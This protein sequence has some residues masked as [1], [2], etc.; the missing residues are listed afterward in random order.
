MKHIPFLSFFTLSLCL[1]YTY[2]HSLYL[3]LPFLYLY[4]IYFKQLRLYCT[5]TSLLFGLKSIIESTVWR[6]EN[7]WDSYM[8]MKIGK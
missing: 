1:S 4:T 8:N 3:S 2:K 6:N 7:V 5:H